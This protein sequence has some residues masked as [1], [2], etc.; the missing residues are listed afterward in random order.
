MIN[1]KIL[2]S[3]CV[4]CERL[5]AITQKVFETPCLKAKIEKVSDYAE[6]MKHPILAAPS[7]VILGNWSPQGRCL[8]GL[9]S[10]GDRMGNFRIY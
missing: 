9:E 1:I 4:N 7:F 8:V 3:Y 6:I 2:G 5:E 10:L